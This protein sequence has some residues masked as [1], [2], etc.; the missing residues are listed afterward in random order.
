[1][2]DGTE[3]ALETQVN[4]TSYNIDEIEG[5]VPAYREKLSGAKIETTDDLLTHCATRSGRKELATRN[6]ENLAT[7]M[8]EVNGEK[9]LAETSPAHSVDSRSPVILAPV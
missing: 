6:A 3:L 1:M 9:S 8:G 4:D 7:K 2:T 5:I